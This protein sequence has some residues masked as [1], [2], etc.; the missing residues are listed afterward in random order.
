MPLGL[1]QLAGRS[2]PVFTYAVLDEQGGDGQLARQ[3]QQ[4][5]QAWQQGINRT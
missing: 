4:D 1:Q 5:Y 2:Q 3:V